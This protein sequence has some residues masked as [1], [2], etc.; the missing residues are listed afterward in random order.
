MHIEEYKLLSLNLRY[1]KGWL[2]TIQRRDF[3]LL[4]WAF[5]S[6][7]KTAAVPVGL[8]AYLAA[9]GSAAVIGNTSGTIDFP[10]VKSV[11]FKD[12]TLLIKL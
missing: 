11:S 10:T 8:Q 9:R 12:H 7:S 3:A 1:C 6:A 4:V 5:G 2:P